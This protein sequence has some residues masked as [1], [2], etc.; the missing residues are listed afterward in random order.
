ME[1]AGITAHIGTIEG[2]HT[3]MHQQTTRLPTGHPP[4]STYRAQDAAPI[5]TMTR[6]AGTIQKLG[7]SCLYD[8]EQTWA[9]WRVAVDGKPADTR[10]KYRGVS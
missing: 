8:K 5:G 10:R 9:H 7:D 6:G 3:H 1:M 4:S 2:R